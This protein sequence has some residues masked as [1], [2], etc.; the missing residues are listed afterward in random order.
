MGNL[1]DGLFPLIS[2]LQEA[3]NVKWL[4][5]RE[6]THPAL[7]HSAR[8]PAACCTQQH[9][10]KSAP[11]EY[12]TCGQQVSAKILSHTVSASKK[13][14]IWV[15]SFFLLSAEKKILFRIKAFVLLHCCLCTALIHCCNTHRLCIKFLIKCAALHPLQGGLVTSLNKGSNT[16]EHGKSCETELKVET[17]N[18]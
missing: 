17:Y 18:S 13:K 14:K 3:F 16:K 11:S 15:F 4:G 1:F 9:T 7:T 2:A 5:W 8:L 10:H 12:T 6:D